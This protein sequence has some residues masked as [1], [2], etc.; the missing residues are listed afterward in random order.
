MFG[1]LSQIQQ[2]TKIHAPPPV[3]QNCHCQW[4]S[5]WLS[6]QCLD[7]PETFASGGGHKISSYQCNVSKIY[8]RTSEKCVCLFYCYV[9]SKKLS[10]E[11]I[12]TWRVGARCWNQSME[13]VKVLN[14]Y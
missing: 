6:G 9:P 14:H 2:S 13:E 3:V 5:R 1:I 4:L 11:N 7:F 12:K 10:A 8:G